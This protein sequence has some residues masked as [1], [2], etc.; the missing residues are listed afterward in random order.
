MILNCYSN[1][2]AVKEASGRDYLNP[3]KSLTPTLS[4]GE[5]VAAAVLKSLSFG[6]GFR[7]RLLSIS[8]LLQQLT[9]N[10]LLK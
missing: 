10:Y 1:F 6:E 4:M 5:G 2:C 7:V 8:N 3:I 9:V